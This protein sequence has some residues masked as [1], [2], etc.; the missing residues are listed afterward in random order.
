[1]LHNGAEYEMGPR[2]VR[3]CGGSTFRQRSEKYINGK[4]NKEMGKFRRMREKKYEVENSRKIVGRRWIETVRPFY[5]SRFLVVWL[6]SAGPVLIPPPPENIKHVK[7]GV[8]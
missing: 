7:I 6:W 2:D 8:I 3:G 5:D 4:L 1:M